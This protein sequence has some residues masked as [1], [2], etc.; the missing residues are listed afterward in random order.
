MAKSNRKTKHVEQPQVTQPITELTTTTT[1]TT[2]KIEPIVL[3][4]HQKDTFDTL[5][6]VSS[7]IRYLHAEKYSRG[8]IASFLNKKYQHVRNVLITPLK[9]EEAAKTAK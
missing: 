6:T 5:T 4:A 2:K 9:K 7:K 8:Q 3:S 1:A